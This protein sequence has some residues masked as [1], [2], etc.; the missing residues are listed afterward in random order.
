MSVVNFFASGNH[1]IDRNADE[2]IE[3]LGLMAKLKSIEEVNRHIDSAKDNGCKR[4]LDFKNFEKEFY[5]DSHIL[6]NITNYQS[7][8]MLELGENMIGVTCFNSSW[9][10]YDSKLDKI[11]YA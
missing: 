8:F 4:V 6:S 2:E 3:E 9:R 11:G 5:S 7:N 1:D 10:C